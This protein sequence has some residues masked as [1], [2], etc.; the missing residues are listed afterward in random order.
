MRRGRLDPARRGR[1]KRI[2]GGVVAEKV[3]L[4]GPI[5]AHRTSPDNTD[6]ARP[7]GRSA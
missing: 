7:A 2:V 4:H 5:A 6:Q 3:E 1:G